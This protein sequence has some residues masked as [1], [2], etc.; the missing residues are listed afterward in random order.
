MKNHNSS[1]GSQTGKKVLGTSGV[2]GFWLEILQS[3][4]A[5]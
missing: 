5:I 1:G 3:Q 4:G 2:Q